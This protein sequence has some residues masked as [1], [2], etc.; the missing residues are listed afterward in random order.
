MTGS[1][2]EPARERDGQLYVVPGERPEAR[3]ESIVDDP[4]PA[5]DGF[6]L[7]DAHVAVGDTLA[8]V[9]LRESEIAPLNNG[10]ILHVRRLEGAA[11]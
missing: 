2:H 7:A 11:V 4:P 3:D 8:V 9:T 10:E 5:A 1:R 6:R